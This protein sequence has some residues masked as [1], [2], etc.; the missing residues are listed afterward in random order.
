MAEDEQGTLS[1][2][3]G[4]FLTEHGAITERTAAENFGIIPSSLRKAIYKLR[5]RGW[6]INLERHPGKESVYRLVLP[7]DG[8][9]PE[10]PAP[11]HSSVI[12]TITYRTYTPAEFRAILVTLYGEMRD[13]EL[14]AFA[15]DDFN[16]SHITIHRWL[17]RGKPITGPA[18][19]LADKLMAEHNAKTKGANLEPT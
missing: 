7:S 6:N 10:L 12:P 18:V 8:Q 13:W 3:V 9:S 4:R 19:A 11:P 14:A 5:L 1:M 17:T 2:R 16:T 15:M